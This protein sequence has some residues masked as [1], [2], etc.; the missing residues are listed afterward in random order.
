[1]AQGNLAIKKLK[2]VE[3][4]LADLEGRLK[5]LPDITDKTE[6]QNTLALINAKFKKEGKAWLLG[7]KGDKHT[8]DDIGTTIKKLRE[9]KKL[10]VNLLGAETI[11]KNKDGLTLSTGAIPDFL[12]ADFDKAKKEYLTEI[13]AKNTPLMIYNPLVSADKRK[14]APKVG[15]T[16][17]G[18]GKFIN[19]WYVRQYNTRIQNKEAREYETAKSDYLRSTDTSGMSE[20]DIDKAVRSGLTRDHSLYLDPTGKQKTLN[21]ILKFN[22]SGVSSVDTKHESYVGKIDDNSKTAG[23][24]EATNRGKLI[25][26]GKKEWLERTKNSPAASFLDPDERWEQQEKH[27]DWLRINNRL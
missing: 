21:P 6:Y 19:P 20:T 10:I 1:M 5:D 7:R 15:L 24:V 27:R 9:Q 26:A 16:I 22:D 14:G 17:G 23:A 4:R 2:I 8:G 12:K 18:K 25:T 13:G 3:A 11:G